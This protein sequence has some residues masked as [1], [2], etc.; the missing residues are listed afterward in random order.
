MPPVPDIAFERRQL[1]SAHTGQKASDKPGTKS[2]PRGPRLNDR[3]PSVAKKAKTAYS[4]DRQTDLPFQKTIR[5]ENK[6]QEHLI[7][8]LI[9]ANLAEH[10]TPIP[11]HVCLRAKD[12]G[13]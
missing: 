5:L 2:R 13:A 4:Q 1:L 8:N 3:A 10:Q 7:L 9:P 6:Q 12:R 11:F